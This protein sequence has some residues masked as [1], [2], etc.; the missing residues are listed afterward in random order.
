M[1]SPANYKKKREEKIK[2]YEKFGV[3]EHWEVKLNKKQVKVDTLENGKFTTFS[4]AKKEGN[5]FSKLL[6]GFKIAIEQLF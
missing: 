1:I 6:Q 5:V 3:K 4:E 2:V